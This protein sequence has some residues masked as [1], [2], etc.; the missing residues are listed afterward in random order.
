MQLRIIRPVRD[1][2]KRR[3]A[4]QSLRS[5]AR[6]DPPFAFCQSADSHMRMPVLLPWSGR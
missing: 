2:E 4:G 6:F 3:L 1:A 5:F